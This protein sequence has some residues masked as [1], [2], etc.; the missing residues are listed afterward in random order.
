M[1]GNITVGKDLNDEK[2]TKI[3]ELEEGIAKLKEEIMN[4]KQKLEKK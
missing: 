2:L 1:G 3:K 4:K